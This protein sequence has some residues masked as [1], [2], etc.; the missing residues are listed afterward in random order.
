MGIIQQNSRISFHTI[1]A[2][3][4]TF[5]VP[6]QEDFTSKSSPWTANDLCLSEIGVN[7]GDGKAYIRIGS[8]IKEFEFVG[9]TAGGES[10]S[11]TLAVGNTMSGIIES[12]NSNTQIYIDNI[13]AS[14]VVSISGTQA[15]LYLDPTENNIGTGIYASDG[16][17]GTYLKIYPDSYIE[18]INSK[19]I[20]KK[21][22][23]HTSTT[24]ATYSIATILGSQWA[25]QGTIFVDAR[26]TATI[27]A[28]DTSFAA[29][30]FAVFNRD[31]SNII[32]QVSTTDAIVKDSTGAPISVDI[33][34]DGTDIFI[35]IV[36]DSSTINWNCFYEYNL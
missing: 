24:S 19:G 29:K 33:N 27:P 17:V 6:S 34:T 18:T 14:F 30:L 11:Q 16:S 13:E 20:Y 9:G 31:V 5:S 7:E 35:Q 12:P 21:N 36:G 15:G 4:S 3:G 23:I 2:T 1:S 10:L 22:T 28:V 26:I 8:D 25:N 32:T